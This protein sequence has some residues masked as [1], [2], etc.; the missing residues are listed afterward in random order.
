MNGNLMTQ[1]DIEEKYKEIHTTVNIA[2]RAMG[3]KARAIRKGQHPAYLYD[4][5]EVVHALQRVY[6]SR[7]EA[8]LIRAATWQDAIDASGK[9][10]EKGGNLN[11]YRNPVNGKLGMVEL[12]NEESK[13]YS[14]MEARE[15]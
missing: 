3:V 12:M 5:E 14:N 4:E 11:D 13:M 6:Q 9:L 8:L 7:K 10:L 2:I 1:K 15:K